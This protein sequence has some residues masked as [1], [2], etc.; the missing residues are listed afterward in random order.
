VV[1]GD[2]DTFGHVSLL[3][4]K[5]HKEREVFFVGFTVLDYE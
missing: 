2:E 1:G 5:A 3:N 4:H